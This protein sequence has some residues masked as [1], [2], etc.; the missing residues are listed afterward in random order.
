MDI[1]DLDTTDM[2]TT[3]MDTTDLDTDIDTGIDLFY[4]LV[5]LA[6]ISQFSFTSSFHLYQH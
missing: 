5:T 6:R 1:T 2:D 4:Q 3:D